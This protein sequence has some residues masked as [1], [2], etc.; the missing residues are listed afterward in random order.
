MIDSLV[1]K[2][3]TALL[4]GGTQAVIAVLGIVVLG[5]LWERHRLVKEIQRKDEKIEKIVD[6]YYKGNITLSDAL[7]SLKIVLYE[8]KAKI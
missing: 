8:I 2:L 5:L 4:G 7:T 6:D 1:E 3:L